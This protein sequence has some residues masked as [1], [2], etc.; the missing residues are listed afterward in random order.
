MV[1]LRILIVEDDPAIGELVRRFLASQGYQVDR[2]VNGQ[3]AKVMSERFRPDLVILDL[4]LPDLNGYELCQ[5]LQQRTGVLVLMLTSRAQEED[6]IQGF[7]RGADDYMTKP[8][9]LME[10]RMRVGALLKR[11]RAGNLWETAQL[12]FGALV[13]DPQSRQVSVAGQV[14]PLTPLEF[15][16][17][18]FLASHPGQIWNRDELIRQVWSYNAEHVGD[19]RV[20]D[21][22]VG[23]I[24]K[25]I[26]TQITPEL[27]ITARIQTVRG[28]GYRFSADP[29]APG[30]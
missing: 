30:L 7:H 11:R 19:P 12:E 1:A 26:Q 18:W 22:H 28:L 5:W 9:S 6:W 23:Q 4:N 20:V 3:Q 17:L 15:N 13:I 24:R 2:A 29:P 14:V 8:F 21:V 27:I 16:L 25:K 10:L